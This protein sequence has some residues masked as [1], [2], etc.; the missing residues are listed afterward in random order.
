MVFY[1]SSPRVLCAGSYIFD[2]KSGVQRRGTVVD[3]APVFTPFA[4]FHGRLPG[5]HAAGVRDRVL[6]RLRGGDGLGNI[7][8]MTAP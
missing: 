7:S 6:R 3:E 2:S 4:G 1:A 8:A 5:R